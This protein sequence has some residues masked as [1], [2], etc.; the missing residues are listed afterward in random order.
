MQ[1]RLFVSCV[2]FVLVLGGCGDDNSGVN[3]PRRRQPSLASRSPRTT[4]T[5][6][7]R[8][9]H[10]MWRMRIRR[11]SSIGPDAI[12]SKRRRSAR[13]SEERKRLRP[14]DSWCSGCVLRRNTT[15][16][17]RPEG[18]A[19]P[20]HWIRRR[21]RPARFRLF[22]VGESHESDTGE[23]RLH[24]HC[25]LGWQHRVYDGVRLRGTRGVVSRVSRRAP[26]R[27]G[28]AAA[29]R[30]LHDRAHDV[31]RRRTGGWAGRRDIARRFARSHVHG[32]DEFVSRWARV[33]AA[34][35]T[36]V[37][38]MARCCFAYTA[39][40]LDLSAHGGPADT[41]VTG[42]QLVRQDASGDQHVVFDAW[43]HFQL[44]DN[45]EPAPGQLDFDHPNAISIA[46]RR[47]LRDVM[48]G[49]GPHHED[50]CEHGCAHLDVGQSVRGAR[51]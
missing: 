1:T 19:L 13:A 10:W 4:T 8:S 36:T 7:R 43:D 5:R 32:A 41:L 50:R 11:V 42:H 37:R 21:S 27:G 22:S 20:S 9:L 38:T 18:R 12:R 44:T 48:E 29:E 2:V 46:P 34:V 31:A 39:R 17:S 51:K 49:S 35:R 40:H 23:L 47:Q 26:A 16:S 33:L 28:Q 14:D 3:S 6:S 45:V 24:P 15:L 30:R 25:D